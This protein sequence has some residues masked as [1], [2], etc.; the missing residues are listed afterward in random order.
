LRTLIVFAKQPVPGK[1]KTRLMPHLSP[2]ACAA[3]YSGFIRDTV[4]TASSASADSWVLAYDPPGAASAMRPFAPAGWDLVPQGD[5]DLGSRMHSALAAH[6]IH[7]GDCAVLIGTDVPSLPAA[8]LN[9]AFDLLTEVDIVLGPSTDGGYY[10]VGLRAPEER[11]FSDITWSSSAVF[12]QS[13]TRART[14]RKTLGLVPPWHD[15]D[16]AEDLNFLIAHADAVVYSG[17]TDRLPH[18]RHALLDLQQGPT[19]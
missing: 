2:E 5:G 8:H 6:L 3:L 4:H 15:V 7:P 17:E 14:L 11:L 16:T 18:T 19:S 9:R 10:L 1:V 13:A 12:A